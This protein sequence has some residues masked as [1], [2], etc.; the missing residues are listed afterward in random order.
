MTNLA[1]KYLG[2]LINDGKD[3]KTIIS[4]RTTLNQFAKWFEETNGYT[5]A[6]KVTPMDIKDF[7]QYMVTILERKPATVNKALVTLKGFFDWTAE[8]GFTNFNPARKVKLV[9][10]QKMAPKWLERTEQNKLLREIEK[11][12][13]EFKRARNLAIAQIMIQAGLRVEEVANLELKD[14]EVNCRSGNVIVRHGKRDKYREVPLN[15]D[16]REAIKD[17]LKLRENHKYKDSQYLFISERSPQITVRAIQHL[18]ERHGESAKIDGLT[19]HILRHTFCHNLI[20][21]GEGIE[22]VAIL[23]GHSS[24]ESTRIYTVPG[25]NELQAA[26]EKIALFE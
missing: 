18:I 26:V 25:K 24:L 21:A 9:E 1:E 15:K 10:K 23:A 7:K 14:I 8:N 5:D 6:E 4:Y 16:A 11:E 19:A 22:K 13:N 17:Y 12:K 3:E 2:E 20:V